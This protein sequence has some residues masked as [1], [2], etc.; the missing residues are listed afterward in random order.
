M[1][2][3]RNFFKQATA[4]AMGGLLLGKTESLSA[5]TKAVNASTGKKNIGLQIYSL[6]DELYDN[7]PER[8]KQPRKMGYTNIEL[9]GYSPDGKIHGVPIMEFKKYVDDADLVIKSTHVQPGVWEYTNSN[10]SQIMDY[11]KKTAEDHA[12][13]G[14]KLLVQPGLPATR[15]IEE[16][17]QVCDV[18]NEV[19]EYIKS[20]GMKF[21]YHNHDMEF[22]RVKSGGNGAVL[23]FRSN[24][25]KIYDLFLENTDPDLVFFEMDCYWTVIGQNDPVEYLQKHP[26]RIQ[27]LHVKDRHVL[28]KSGFMNF[29]AI[30]NQANENGITNFF[31]E[32]EGMP[33]GKTQM[34]GV[35]ECAKYLLKSK[36][37]K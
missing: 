24:D 27:A 21:G 2:N 36:F 35:E 28:G 7:L 37:V 14:V 12:K 18:F 31:V 5:A 23:Q 33:Q 13:M 16:V 30:F 8:L 26:T 25:P 1:T 22:A 19:G 20:N 9:A 11:W 4:L 10:K 15:S 3:R 29:E 34:E 32:L 6:F 17:K